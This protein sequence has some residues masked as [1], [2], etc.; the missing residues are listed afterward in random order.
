MNSLIKTIEFFIKNI[1]KFPI[2][3]ES[4]KNRKTPKERNLFRK[5]EEIK[6]LKTEKLHKNIQMKR[7]TPVSSQEKKPVLK[8]K[9]SI[10][11][12]AKISEKKTMISK[13]KAGLLIKT[14]SKEK[15]PVKTHKEIQNTKENEEKTEETPKEL[16]KTSQKP[17]KKPK[18]KLKI[19]SEIS[20]EKTQEK[21]E[22][23]EEKIPKKTLKKR[24]KKHNTKKKSA[25]KA[26]KP[27]VF[28]MKSLEKL[29]KNPDSSEM[30][31]ISKLLF[32]SLEDFKGFFNDIF[33]IKIL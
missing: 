22:K 13:E 27:D 15:K 30:A 4:L 6:F 23:N 33:S 31:S 25:K 26:L 24:R 1:E 12:E 18:K 20:Q 9:N 16:K 10:L 11:N 2:V 21:L 28:I 14:E 3:I 8:E 32:R 19:S 29:E 17:L 7:K 5:D